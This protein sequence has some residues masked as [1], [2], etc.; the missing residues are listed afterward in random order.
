MKWIEVIGKCAEYCKDVDKMFE[1]PSEPCALTAILVT[2]SLYAYDF[3]PE[4]CAPTADGGISISCYREKLKLEVEVDYDCEM[5]V[6]V[7]REGHPPKCLS[8]EAGKID[9]LLENLYY[10]GL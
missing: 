8:V 9:L 3:V 10:T 2:H 4:Y 7:T 5:S 1:T 6:S